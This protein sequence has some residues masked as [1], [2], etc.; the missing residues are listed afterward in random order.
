MSAD[1][2]NDPLL[3]TDVYNQQQLSSQDHGK[4]SMCDSIS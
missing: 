3:I 2:W 4:N 1:R